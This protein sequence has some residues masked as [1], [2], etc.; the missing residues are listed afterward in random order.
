MDLAKAFDTVDH[1]ILLKKLERY[2]IRGHASKLI[3]NY[4]RNRQ[5]KVIIQGQT[6]EPQTVRTGVPQGTILGPFLFLIYINDLL[7]LLPKNI[8]SYADD[9]A[10]IASGISW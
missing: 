6:C 7:L 10:V 1:V 8:F 2:G 4:L 3:A 5:Q 9:T